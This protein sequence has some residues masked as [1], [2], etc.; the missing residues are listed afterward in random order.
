MVVKSF[1]TTSSR[2]SVFFV[3]I[4]FNDERLKYYLYMEKIEDKTKNNSNNIC[5]V[6]WFVIEFMHGIRRRTF[7]V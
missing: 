4:Y 1:C 3:T 7:V 6:S 5:N 2:P